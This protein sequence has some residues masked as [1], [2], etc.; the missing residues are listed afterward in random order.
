M[1]KLVTD[2]PMKNSTALSQVDVKGYLESVIPTTDFKCPISTSRNW[3]REKNT[4]KDSGYTAVTRSWLPVK[5]QAEVAQELGATIVRHARWLS[6]VDIDEVEWAKNFK[7]EIQKRE[8]STAWF[9]KNQD[10]TDEM[11]DY[12]IQEYAEDKANDEYGG[13][14]FLERKLLEVG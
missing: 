2:K 9:L 5:D 10:Y 3:Q 7:Y 13:K 8:R 6:P 14:D 4:K 1:F 11:R 12:L